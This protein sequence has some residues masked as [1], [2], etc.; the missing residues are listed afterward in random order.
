MFIVADLVSLT[1]FIGWCPH[2]IYNQQV[3]TISDMESTVVGVHCGTTP[4]P[5]ILVATDVLSIQ[6]YSDGSVEGK[7]FNATY[8]MLQGIIVTCIK[9]NKH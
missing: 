1:S 6:F 9:E 3:T 7:G 4:P 5:P 8:A 2:V